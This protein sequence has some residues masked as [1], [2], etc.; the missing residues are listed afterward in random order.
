[1]LCRGGGIK[2]L[3]R[4]LGS[5][6][7]QTRNPVSVTIQLNFCM[8]APS[9]TWVNADQLEKA[10]AWRQKRKLAATEK[11]RIYSP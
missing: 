10:P 11:Q 7:T 4:E 2:E 3:K 6:E 8:M 1:M 5:A 9:L